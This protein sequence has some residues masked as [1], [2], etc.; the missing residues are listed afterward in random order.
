MASQCNKRT[1]TNA[2]A[3]KHKKVRTKLTEAYLKERPEYIQVRINKIRNSVGDKRSR[4]AWQTV[5]E[6]SKRK[7][8]SRAKL[9][10]ATQEEQIQMGK[11]ISRICLENPLKLQINLSQKGLIINKISKVRQFTQEE[12]NVVLTKIQNSKI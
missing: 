6:V 11:D 4:I 5:N 10:A 12:L 7:S 2:N 8:I 1:P 9:K 3:Q